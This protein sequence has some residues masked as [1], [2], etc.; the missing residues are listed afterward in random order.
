MNEALVAAV[1]H[2]DPLATT[3]SIALDALKGRAL[4]SL[5]RGTGPRACLDNACASIRVQPRIAFEASDLNVVQLA[6]RGLGVRGLGV[7]M[8]PESVARVFATTLHAVSIV[9][10]EPRGTVP[11]AWRAEGPISPAAQVLVRY[12]RARLRIGQD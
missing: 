4:I 11:L 3:E 8:L 7:A 2:G 1:Q 5:P 12:A 9:N 10:P 6:V